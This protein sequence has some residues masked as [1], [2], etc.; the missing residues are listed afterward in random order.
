MGSLVEQLRRFGFSETEAETYRAVLELGQAG[1]GTVADRAG[2]SKGYAYEVLDELAERGVVVVDDHLT[3]T[4][5]RAVDPDETVADFEAELDRLGETLAAHYSHTDP[6]HPA[7]EVVKSRQAM[8]RRLRRAVERATDSVYL[9]VPAPVIER[10]SGPL[11]DA[12]D[13][14]VFVTLL[15]GDCPPGDAADLVRGRATV[16]RAWDAQFPFAVAADTGV[17]MTGDRGLLYGEHDPEE[18]GLVVR[19]S[20][21]LASAVGALG[22]SFWTNAGEA[23]VAEPADLPSRYD[24][25]Q[26]AVVDAT[27]H[28]RAGREVVAVAETIGDDAVTGRVVGTRQSLVEPQTADFPT[29]NTLVVR[30]EAG[31][32]TVG[33]P[34]A[35]VEDYT[36]TGVTLREG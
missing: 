21:K 6:D 1:V 36:A 35:F 24:H 26:A 16:A 8:D 17:A 2:L 19:N 4:Q 22:A 11:T 15:V 3:P 23:H 14:G 12:V 33:G 9:T 28:R 5:V 10:L 18:F 7:V 30:T 29:E 13:R 25:F 27:L 20:S 34:G 32:V 31:E